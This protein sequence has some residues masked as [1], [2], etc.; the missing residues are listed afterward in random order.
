MNAQQDT[1]LDLK[2]LSER[3][4]LSVRWLRDYL[5]PDHPSMI[6]HYKTDG[7]ILVRW[8]EFVDWL[9]QFR[10]ESNFREKVNDVVIE[11]R[12]K[13]KLRQQGRK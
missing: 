7:K 5:K 6:P 11:L 10:V 9:G 2:H 4:N 8:P 13:D 1:I 3:T 12:N